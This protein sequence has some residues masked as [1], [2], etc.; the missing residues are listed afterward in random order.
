LDGFP[1][2]IKIRTFKN[3]PISPGKA[4]DNILLFKEGG[5]GSSDNTR[6]NISTIL[7]PK[8]KQKLQEGFLVG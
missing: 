4:I 7:D 5:P 6:Q 3:K 8:S 1:G 2:K